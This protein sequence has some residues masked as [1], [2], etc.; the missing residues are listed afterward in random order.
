MYSAEFFQNEIPLPTLIR[1]QEAQ[2][3]MDPVDPDPDSDPQ[4]CGKPYSGG[5]LLYSLFTFVPITETELHNTSFT[6]VHP[7]SNW[8]VSLEQIRFFIGQIRL[9]FLWLKWRTHKAQYFKSWKKTV[10]CSCFRTET[11]A[12]VVVSAPRTNLPV[13]PMVAREDAE[14]L[15]KRVK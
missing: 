15:G 8:E 5:F 9:L 2:K 6:F 7:G 14:S 13:S 11:P 3:H 1:T 4:H 12:D 10:T